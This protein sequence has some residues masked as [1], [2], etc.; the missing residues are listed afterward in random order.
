MFGYLQGDNK[1]KEFCILMILFFSLSL[2]STDVS[3]NIN[4]VWD[5]NQS[6]YNVIGDINITDSLIINPGVT[7]I[8]N[9][10]YQINVS[11]WI[12]AD[13]TEIDSIMFVLS[14]IATEW[15]GIR[16][17]GDEESTFSYCRVSGTGG[18]NSCGIK[19]VTSPVIIDHCLINNHEKGID[20]FA[21]GESNPPEMIVRN[22][23]V[24]HI[25]DA[26]ITIAENGNVVIEDCEI[27]QCALSGSWYGGIHLTV[28]TQGAEVS[29]VIRRNTIHHN[30]RQGMIISDLMGVGNVN[31]QVYNNLVQFNYTGIYSANT[32]GF[33]QNN[34]VSYNYETGNA[35]SGAGIMCFGPRSNA[36]FSGNTISHNYAG[37]Y[38]NNNA[39]P[40]LG[41]VTNFETNDDGSNSIH[42]NE[43]NGTANSVVSGSSLDIFAQNNSWGE[44]DINLIAQSIHE[45]GSG[46]V[47]FTPISSGAR[48]SITG[49]MYYYGTNTVDSILIKVYKVDSLDTPLV[50]TQSTTGFYYVNVPDSGDY[51]VTAEAIFAE[52]V[53]QG[54]G[55]YGGLLDPQI[56]TV[57][58]F[59]NDNNDFTIFDD[60]P[61]VSVVVDAA[62]D[63]QGIMS[64]PVHFR[65]GVYT[66]FTKY[67]ESNNAEITVNGVVVERDSTRIF[68]YT[69]IDMIVTECRF[70]PVSGD[71]WNYS[72][73]EGDF[74]RL[75]EA[76][77][78]VSE[79]V[80]VDG[81]QDMADI[82][83]IVD[84]G[85]V[86]QQ[87]WYSD[88]YG[89]YRMKIYEYINGVPFTAEY[90]KLKD[91]NVTLSGNDFIQQDNV[92]IFSQLEPDHPTDLIV[93]PGT[94]NNTKLTW[95]PPAYSDSIS[96]DGYRV[97]DDGT[98]VTTLPINTLT[99]ELVIN[100]NVDLYIVAYNSQTE[101]DRTNIKSIRLTDSDSD[102][103]PVN[104]YSAV[105]YPNP[106]NPET[107][108]EFNNVRKQSVN[109][110]IYNMKGQK[111]VQ[112][113]DDVMEEGVNKL[114]WK[115]LDENGI[116]VGSGVYFYRINTPDRKLDRKM[117]LLK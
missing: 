16:L 86:V 87:I 79:S 13:G 68:D 42:D 76:E 71:I 7:V 54:Y 10:F 102:V 44:F 59:A 46:Q 110:S 73:V 41:N 95:S 104:Y 28:Q 82:V 31:P 22:T 5:A 43:M 49:N 91:L 60:N 4:G 64:Y 39:Q 80:T 83:E 38:I 96:W 67:M 29:P 93:S 40:N 107:T 109:V 36:V 6:P 112:L 30:N 69:I 99:Y 17:E 98:L 78:V 63:F 61:V 108:I 27:T 92:W 62:E 114:H 14:D 84:N 57:H 58:S 81:Q 85:T 35:D 33:Y 52:D 74:A 116:S 11:G 115:G 89:Y 21:A 66:G 18:Q 77:Y 50:Y 97:Y 8:V 2:F 65:S 34:I 3:G 103:N 1:M 70:N 113:F 20:L 45:L 56:I 15:K 72:A 105:N 94:G 37:F 75:I 47:I 24:S 48:P 101:S 106:F 111:V 12:I 9:G 53:P 23:F 117:L 55:I 19:V 25:G 88:N 51:Y 26:G 32:S 100:T 90:F